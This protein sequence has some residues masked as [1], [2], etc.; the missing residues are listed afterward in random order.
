MA[1]FEDELRSGFLDE[2][3]DLLAQAESCFL[4]LEKAQEDPSILD[5]ILRLAHNFKGS[6]RAVGFTA[7]SEFTHRFET[8]LI[9]IKL[10]EIVINQEVIN[11]LLACNDYLKSSI[12]ELRVDQ[13]SA[14]QNQALHQRVEDCISRISP[15]SEPPSQDLEA[16]GDPGQALAEMTQSQL[17]TH[18]TK[19][20]PIVGTPDGDESIRVALSR[21]DKLMNNVGELV[22]LQTGLF[23][24][25]HLLQ[26]SSQLSSVNQM[27]KIIR[28]VQ[29]ITMSL[30]MTAITQTFQKMRRIVRDTSSALSKKVELEVLGEDIELDKNVLELLTDP[31]THLIRNAVDHG[32]ESNEERAASGKPPEGRIQLVAQHSGG[33]VVIEVKDDGKGLDPKKLIAKAIE[34]GVLRSDET[35]TDEQAY[36]LIFA[37]G[38]S[39]KEQVTDISG[40]GVG[41]DVVKTNITALQGEVTIKTKLGKGTTFRVSLPLTLAIVEAMVVRQGQ[42]RY[43]IP[44]VQVS[45]TIQINKDLISTV[46][47][48]GQVLRLRDENIPIFGLGQILGSTSKPSP[49]WES[50]GIIVRDN[51]RQ[52]RCMLVD[53]I[54]G[55]QQVVIK[56]LGNEIHWLSGVMG[57]AILGDGEAALILDIQELVRNRSP[58]ATKSTVNQKEAV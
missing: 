18:A 28:E 32:L 9:K 21:I 30:R 8:L 27:D 47:E 5:Q 51:S 10:G 29:E 15:A 35:L 2:A 25:R 52:A 4:N 13:N 23:Q 46:G 57:A 54:I 41:L 17:S 53:Q 31:L 56:Q 58:R 37:P 36:Q 24:T 16:S 38:F 49:T 48:R 39:T 44:I 6:A 14:C 42:E 1:D 11:L 26:S 50:V 7:L 19:R 40:R 34:K 45:E 55:Q 33:R 12:A 20:P 22:I 43:V 3:A